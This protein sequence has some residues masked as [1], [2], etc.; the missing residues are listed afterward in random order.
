MVDKALFLN[1]TSAKDIM[2]ATNR[3]ANNLA[4]ANTPGFKE[5]LR[6][7]K[8]Q[9][10]TNQNNAFVFEDDIAQNQ[11][12]NSS[13]RF[14]QG[15]IVNTGRALDVAISGE[16]FFAVQNQQGI[17]AYT[18]TGNLQINQDGFLTTTKGDFL[19]GEN[20]LINVGE[21]DQVSINKQGLVSA[22]IRGES[23]TEIA[24][25]GR[26]K[27]VKPALA[28]LNKGQDGLFYLSDGEL[29]QASLDVQLVSES[30]EGS[31]V[32]PVRAL[33]DLID[34][35]RQF[36]YQT[37]IMQNLEKNEKTANHLYDVTS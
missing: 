31:N 24:D 32:E 26:I 29:A 22:K 21:A 16:G 14:S 23:D 17:E 28:A 6:E 15:P 19:L 27:V 4:N 20:G 5:D 3:I 10:L 33:V 37:K 36:E 7:V 30:L 35:S 9:Q 13:I 8:T 2:Q 11:K 12:A 18:R 34:M 1:M 25:L